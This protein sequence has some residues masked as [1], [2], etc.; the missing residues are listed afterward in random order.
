MG[1]T[2]AGKSTFIKNVTGR[3]DIEIGHNLTS[4]ELL[5]A[6]G[7]S[8]FED[9]LTLQFVE[10]LECRSYRFKY[11]GIN[12]ALVDTPGFNDTYLDDA[13]ILAQLSSFMETA[14]RARVKLT[15]IIYLHPIINDRL[16]GSALDNLSMFRKLCGPKFYP[17]VVLATTFWG[18]VDPA[19]GSRR[20]NE[21]K[22]TDEFWGSMCK[23]GSEVIRLPDDRFDCITLLLRLASKIKMSLQIQEELVD[24]GLS[25]SQTAAGASARNVKALEALREEFS[26][27]MD[28]LSAQK[29]AE[30][31]KQEAALAKL[32][33]EQEHAFQEQLKK[34]REEL[35]R[36][37]QNHQKLLAEAEQRQRKLLEEQ[38]E[39]VQK[40]H[41]ETEAARV[42]L[43]KLAMKDKED[44][45]KRER[46]NKAQKFEAEMAVAANGAIAQ[47]ELFT[48][49]L[50]V[51]T[52][53]A[54]TKKDFYF[55]LG[56]SQ[57]CNVCLR[58]CSTLLSY[59]KSLLSSRMPRGPGSC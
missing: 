50:S 25:I 40:T 59:G 11:A 56:L 34:Y 52:V 47:D 43:E 55:D 30:I 41:A 12:M 48:S 24:Q 26:K 39:F 31:A 38:A 49:A 17:N 23:R 3:A 14:Y 33:D 6:F 18:N 5:I 16:E 13:A 51:G 19:V 35:E 37:N 2:G 42:E 28:D 58:Q 36:V 22:E 21:L 1:I 7:A 54:K 9:R 32:R 57:C 10:T 29:K 53:K 4:G 27:R 44:Q 8:I 20:E 15:A 45:E 46:K